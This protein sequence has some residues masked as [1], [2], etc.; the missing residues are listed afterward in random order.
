VLSDADLLTSRVGSSNCQTLF[1][2]NY[3]QIKTRSLEY[4]SIQQYSP[5]LSLDH[6]SIRLHNLFFRLE[7]ATTLPQHGDAGC[8]AHAFPSFIQN[9]IWPR[10][11]HCYRCNLHILL[12]Q[13]LPHDLASWQTRAL[14]ARSTCHHYNRSYEPR[15]VPQPRLKQ[16]VV[17]DDTSH[18]YNSTGWDEEG[19]R[20]GGPDVGD[21]DWK[22]DSHE[23]TTGGENA[24]ARTG[25]ERR[26]EHGTDRIRRSGWLGFRVFVNMAWMWKALG[27]NGCLR[28]K[29]RSRFLH[30]N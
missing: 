6:S 1:H 28:R 2:L 7:S 9:I 14:G 30:T 16:R 5:N 22:C 12:R 17:T 20:D 13:N 4:C 19:R 23:T 24:S 29:R 8:P 10:Q 27:L 25:P 18:C 11:R 21:D 15:N 26:R 3:I